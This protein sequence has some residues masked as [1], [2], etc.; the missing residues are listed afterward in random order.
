MAAACSKEIHSVHKA[1]VVKAG[2]SSLEGAV[3]DYITGND[4]IERFKVISETLTEQLN[5]LER[6]QKAFQKLW[7]T[8]RMQIDK[9]QISLVEIFGD[10]D[11][12]SDGNIKSIEDFQL[13]ID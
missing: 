10:L 8:R 7:R 6:E 11:A 4:F 3:Y 12:L 5:D 2:K 9:S 1:K 13:S